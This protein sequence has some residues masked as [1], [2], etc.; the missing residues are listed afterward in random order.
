[1]LSK[2]YGGAL[3]LSPKTF[4]GDASPEVTYVKD[5][6]VVPALE[7]QSVLQQQVQGVDTDMLQRQVQGTDIDMPQQQ[8]QS[9]HAG[10]P[11]AQAIEAGSNQQARNQDLD[12][13]INATKNHPYKTA[14]VALALSATVLYACNKNFRQACNKALTKAKE[15]AKSVWSGIKN[16][17]IKTIT[18]TAEAVVLTMLT[19]ETWDHSRK[20]SWL[21]KPF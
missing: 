14:T 10:L 13:L 12:R 8:A 20:Q 7:E 1:V 9:T 18:G 4:A 2:I 17:P 5:E 15:A 3:V 11:Q 16:N 21:A 19:K 6:L